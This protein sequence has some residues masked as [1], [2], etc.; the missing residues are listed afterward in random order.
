MAT[1]SNGTS[2]NFYDHPELLEVG[3]VRLDIDI[4]IDSHRAWLGD[5]QLDL[6]GPHAR[7]VSSPTSTGIAPLN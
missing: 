1:A 3:N 7:D 5:A 2:V 4:D 6:Q